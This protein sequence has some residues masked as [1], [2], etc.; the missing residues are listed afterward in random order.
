[1][2]LRS[3]GRTDLG[4]RLSWVVGLPI[5]KCGEKRFVFV[6]F[7]ESLGANPWPTDLPSFNTMDCSLRGLYDD[8]PTSLL[9]CL[10]EDEELVPEL[11]F[12]YHDRLDDDRE[13]ERQ[14]EAERLASARPERKEKKKR[15]PPTRSNFCQD[16]DAAAAP[17]SPSSS[18]RSNSRGNSSS[19]TTITSRGAGRRKSKSAAPA[20]APPSNDAAAAEGG[21]ARRGR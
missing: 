9:E 11:L 21:L 7:P 3:V 18:S 20:P 5:W 8:R 16:C 19:T 17:T 13:S 2:I 1:M 10:D 15:R 14:R 12:A 4:Y 6:I